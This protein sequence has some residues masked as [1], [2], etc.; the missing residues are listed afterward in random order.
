MKEAKEDLIKRTLHKMKKSQKHKKKVFSYLQENNPELLWNINK[1]SKIK[2]CWNYLMFKK[3]IEW[4]DKLHSWNFCRYDKICLACATR[5]AILQIK[6][7][8]KWIVDNWLENKYWYHI[9]PT[10]RHNKRQSLEKVIEKLFEAKKKLASDYRNSKRKS[11]KTKSFFSQFSWMVISTEISYWKNGY[12][13]HFHILACCDKPLNTEQSKY[14]STTSNRELQKE[15]Y[16]YSNKLWKQ[17]WMRSIWVQKNN[18]NRQGLGEIFKYVVKN[19]Q[20]EMPQL[21]ELLKLQKKKQYRFLS[22]Y[23]ICRGWK[24]EKESKEKLDITKTFVYDNETYWIL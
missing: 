3:S 6:R 23:W 8:E 13:P 7:F 5:R 12:H 17:V 4:E 18:F 16:K 11:Q 9:T 22:T 2:D 1:R 10:I 21:V 19:S 20:L 14:M 24:I 15:W